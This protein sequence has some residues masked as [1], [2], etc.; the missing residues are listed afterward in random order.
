MET[1]LYEILYIIDSTLDESAQ[2][3]IE[4][5][6]KKIIQDGGGEIAKESNWG[7]QT[8]AYPIKKRTEGIYV[9]MEFRATP[10]IPEQINQYEQTHAGILRHLTL[11]VPKAK[12]IQE[13]RDEEKRKRELAEAEKARK[14]AL[15][16]EAK[17]EMEA[18]MAENQ[19]ETPSA[20]STESTDTEKPKETSAPA[21]E[22]TE[23]KAEPTS[24]TTNQE[25]TPA[26][27]QEQV[28]TNKP[29]AE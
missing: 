24:E 22:S 8:L 2:K 15:A 21:V 13:K 26:P 17:R 20:E 16:A 3:K 18:A 25:T 4:E 27:Q 5:D 10:D 6:I 7:K 23:G 1:I 12:L 29:E 14:A 28:E 19:T 11:K 9:N